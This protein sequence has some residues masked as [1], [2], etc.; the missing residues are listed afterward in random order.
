MRNMVCQQIAVGANG[1]LLYS[2]GQLLNCREDADAK[3]RYFRI[4]CDVAREVR[5]QIPI[6]LLE[7][8]PKFASK[9][10]R[11]RVRTWRDGA[12]VYALVCNTHPEPRTGMVRIEGD[13]SICKIVFGGGVSSNGGALVLD[14]EPFGVAIVKLR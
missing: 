6:L 10:E 2:Y 7:P 4:S 1:I 3:E 5:D 8:G 9:P 11:V 13:Y 12:D 14:M